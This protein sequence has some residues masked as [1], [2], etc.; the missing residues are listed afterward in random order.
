[1]LL[2]DVVDSPGSAFMLLDSVDDLL[3]EDLCCWTMSITC[4]V[5]IYAA[6]RCRRLAKCGFM[7]LECVDDL[8]DHAFMLLD[9]VVDLLSED[10]CRMIVTKD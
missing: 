7:L 2:D 1:M 3:S 10:L 6:G 5:W 8:L 4:K 9:D